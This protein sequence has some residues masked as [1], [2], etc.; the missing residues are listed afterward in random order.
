M[1]GSPAPLLILSDGADLQT[2]LARITRAVASLLSRSPEYR[3]GTLGLG[4]IGSRQLPFQQYQIQRL[5]G[6]WGVGSFAPAWRDFSGGE[7]GVVFT[8]WDT[9]RLTWFARPDLWLGESPELQRFLTAKHFQRWGYVP[10][11]ATGPGDRLTVISRDV[12]MGYDRLVAYTK[13]GEGV[14]RRTIGDAA[15]DAR[16]LTWLPHGIDFKMFQPRARHEG[17][18]M[19]GEAVHESDFVVGMVGTNQA[20]KDWGT[21]CAALSRLRQSVRGLRIWWHIDLD[22]RYWSA[23]AL[24]TDFGLWDITTVTHD[25]TDSQLSWHYSACDVTMLPTLGEGF[26]YP[27]AESLACGT[28][29]ITTDYA[30][31]AETVGDLKGLLVEPVA[32]RLDTLHNCLRPVTN[33]EHWTAKLLEVR[34]QMPSRDDCRSA[35]A[36]LDWANL[37]PSCWAKW[38]EEARAIL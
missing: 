17:R 21:A 37:W 9:T 34:D 35:I 18:R 13:W 7:T 24:L 5:Q 14:I 16:H 20:R 29:C 6:E 31:G 11:D 32:F 4:G 23:P 36:H 12:L 1:L 2:G 30:G 15:A 33:P 10:V 8:I 27:I 26:G 19:M 28:P 22:E 38:F 25:L 3:V